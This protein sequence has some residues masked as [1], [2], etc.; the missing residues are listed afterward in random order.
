MVYTKINR[1]CFN[2]VQIV[3]FL[4]FFF[5]IECIAL[6]SR[7]IFILWIATAVNWL[8]CVCVCGM[9][10]SPLS[11]FWLSLLYTLCV[12][13]V[14]KY[15]QTHTHTLKFHRFWPNGIFFLRLQFPMPLRCLTSTPL[16]FHSLHVSV[17]VPKRIWEKWLTYLAY[18]HRHYIHMNNY[19][20]MLCSHRHM[21]LCFVD[22]QHF[23]QNLFFLFFFFSFKAMCSYTKKMFIIFDL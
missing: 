7:N 11:W 18:I 3:F 12:V 6:V 9:Y 22:S 8:M 14:S 13:S 15:F 5:H 10:F 4:S 17:L 16:Y 21:Y 2:S 1:S 20:I 19:R 23:D